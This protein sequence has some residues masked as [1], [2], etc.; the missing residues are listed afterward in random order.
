M[1]QGL[2]RSRLFRFAGLRGGGLTGRRAFALASPAAIPP[3]SLRDGGGMQAGSV[4]SV[5]ADVGAREA[6]GRSVML[7]TVIVRLD[8]TTQ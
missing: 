3:A 5:S 1:E 6:A 8:R 2:C 7:R 4:W